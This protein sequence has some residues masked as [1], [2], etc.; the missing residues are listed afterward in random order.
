MDFRDRQLSGV[1][2]AAAW[3]RVGFAVA[4]GTIS[5]VGTWSMPVA[6]PF[7]PTDS[8]LAS[9][10]LMILWLPTGF[11]AKGYRSYPRSPSPGLP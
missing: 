8:R 5:S 9:L 11:S 4:I 1:D 3:R 6:L 2:S 10:L 7:V